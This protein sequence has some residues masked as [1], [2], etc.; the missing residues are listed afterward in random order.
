M[1]KSV[2]VLLV[3]SLILVGCSGNAKQT[4][5]KEGTYYYVY[6]TDSSKFPRT[7][8][9]M[10]TDKNY[11]TASLD[12]INISIYTYQQIR[13]KGSSLDLYLGRRYDYSSNRIEKWSTTQFECFGDNI[14]AY[15]EYALLTDGYFKDG[16]ISFQKN[17]SD[18]S[19]L[20][21]L[22]VTEQYAK[23]NNYRIIKP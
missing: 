15:D 9:T 3:S 14:V 1:K 8:I 23:D 21:S 18:G 22:F 20:W 11:T 7:I 6:M 5:P 2:L 13:I 16:A 17:M 10:E 4:T 12:D 19:V